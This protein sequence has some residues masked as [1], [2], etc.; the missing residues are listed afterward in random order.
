MQR[1]Y[2]SLAS[3]KVEA[4]NMNIM[5]E[6]WSS[7]QCNDKGKCIC[8]ASE[9]NSKTECCDVH[10]FVC[11]Q[12]LTLT[13]EWRSELV[14]ENICSRSYHAVSFDVE[15]FRSNFRRIYLLTQL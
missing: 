13:L 8:S 1:I 5:S 15:Y 11:V 14:G 12:R 7:I 4:K 3:A 9:A 6:K 2:F 10:F